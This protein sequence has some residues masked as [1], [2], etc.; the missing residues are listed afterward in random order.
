VAENGG[1]RIECKDARSQPA[2]IEEDAGRVLAWLRDSA[3]RTM[4]CADLTAWVREQNPPW[5]GG[6]RNAVMDRVRAIIAEDNAMTAADWRSLMLR[7]IQHLIPHCTRYKTGTGPSTSGEGGGSDG[8]VFLR[9]P[10]T[11]EFLKEIDHGAIQG[12]FQLI[13]KLTGTMAEK[14]QHEHLHA[15]IA[16]GDLSRV[17][18]EEL[19]RVIKAASAP[20]ISATEGVACPPPQN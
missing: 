2:L 7:Q 11:G 15:A 12:Y 19:W 14:H 10:H 8:T 18:D 13:G 17:P 9:D 16:T 4:C 1:G 20:R 3:V 5:T 6:Y